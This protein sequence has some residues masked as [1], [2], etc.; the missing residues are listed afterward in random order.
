MERVWIAIY[1]FIFSDLKL[2]YYKTVWFKRLREG[3]IDL[4]SITNGASSCDDED[5]DTPCYCVVKFG[6]HFE[7]NPVFQSAQQMGAK[8]I[9]I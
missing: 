3:S 8:V 6:E 7:N 1:L 2:D 4:K 9:A 5:E